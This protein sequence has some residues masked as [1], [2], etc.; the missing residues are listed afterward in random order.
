MKRAIC[1]VLMGVSG[2]GKSTFASALASQ[3][4]AGFIEGDDLHPASNIGKM[5]NGIPLNDDDRWPWLKAIAAKVG[6]DNN[7]VFV[8]CSAL[9][10]TYRRYLA[11]QIGFECYFIHLVGAEDVLAA[12]IKRRQESQQGH[13]M[14]PILLASQV[15]ILEPP[16]KDEPH[17]SVCVSGS[18]DQVFEKILHEVRRKLTG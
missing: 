6:Q 14:P 3:L 16:D 18:A 15:A 9:K 2:S 7:L 1:F 8:A 13:F 11:E 17:C 4:K 10:K 12:R 5:S